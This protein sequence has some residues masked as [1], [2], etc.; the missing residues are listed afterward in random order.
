LDRDIQGLGANLK[1]I[2]I[3]VMPVLLTVL[4]GLFVGLRR[5]RGREL[6]DAE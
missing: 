2:N 5:I 3:A 4:L 6:A 1:L